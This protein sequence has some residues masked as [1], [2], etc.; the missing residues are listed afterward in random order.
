M[1]YVY[2]I[3]KQ[4]TASIGKL[5]G[6]QNKA[7]QH[8]DYKNIS[9]LVT[10]HSQPISSNGET[11]FLQHAAVVESIF[12]S[13]TILP[14]QF[15]TSLSDRREVL[16]LLRRN[17]EEFLVRLRELNNHVEFGIKVLPEKTVEDPRDGSH[18]PGTAYLHEK[19]GDHHEAR[20][21]GDIVNS[22]LKSLYTQSTYQ[23]RLSPTGVIDFFYLVPLK[24][25]HRFQESAQSLK[26]DGKCL[27]TGP[28]PPYNF[29]TEIGT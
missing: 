22:R 6:L 11:L 9:A 20:A 12:E 16:E 26:V 24:K 25:I 8:I 21:I 23:P 2:G 7:V 27:V 29:V 19:F 1:E 14:F 4:G 5:T 17:A 28:W 15:G 13:A 18:G 10:S 3:V